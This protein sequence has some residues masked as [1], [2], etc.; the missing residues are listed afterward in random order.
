MN[1]TPDRHRWLTSS[2]KLHKT[3]RWTIIAYLSMSARPPA[4]LQDF[5]IGL[6]THLKVTTPHY[7]CGPTQL[8]AEHIRSF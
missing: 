1:I 3:T 2:K 6:S 8:H 4:G 5:T 7:R